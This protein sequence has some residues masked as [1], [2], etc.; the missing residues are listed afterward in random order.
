M[1]RKHS[2][3]IKS[4]IFLVI[5]TACI[6]ISQSWLLLVKSDHILYSLL[7]GAVVGTLMFLVSLAIYDQFNIERIVSFLKSY[8]RFPAFFLD[9]K[10]YFIKSAI[11]TTMEELFWRGFL[12]EQFINHGVSMIIVTFIFTTMHFNKKS[13][14]VFALLE[15]LVY[16]LVLAFIFMKTKNIYLV[17][18]MHYVRNIY[19]EFKG[20]CT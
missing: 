2:K 19:I 13:I 18:A 14:Y 8:G 11:I 1:L 15:F 16:F 3:L 4:F 17:I 9:Y 10:R 20:Y 12:Q 7:Q 6:V 5:P